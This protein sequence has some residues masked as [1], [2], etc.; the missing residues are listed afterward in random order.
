MITTDII[1]STKKGQE[2][3]CFIEIPAKWLYHHGDPTKVVLKIADDITV[4]PVLVEESDNNCKSFAEWSGLLRKSP[5]KVGVL[6][7]AFRTLHSNA[8]AEELEQV[9]GNVAG[10]LKWVRKDYGYALKLIWDSASIPNISGRHLDYMRGMVRGRKNEAQKSRPVSYS[11]VSD[12]KK[13]GK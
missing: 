11:S 10:L 4:S 12:L 6:I 8:P 7:K 3:K 1:R 13:E 5:N 2:G 9:G